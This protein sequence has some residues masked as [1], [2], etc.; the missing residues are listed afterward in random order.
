[1]AEVRYRSLYTPFRRRRVYKCRIAVH[2]LGQQFQNENSENHV[3]INFLIGRRQAVRADMKVRNDECEGRLKI[4]GHDFV[5]SDTVVKYIDINAWGCTANFDPDR[6]P[7]ATAG[8]RV[9]DFVS[10]LVAHLQPF[11]FI[12]IGRAT[13]G[14]RYW[15]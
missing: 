12:Y 4:S 5:L 9:K 14:C 6:S 3:V 15:V 7:P 13:D 8:Y 2:T 11:R 10:L 1:M